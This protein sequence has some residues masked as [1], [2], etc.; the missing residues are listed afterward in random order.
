[1]AQAQPLSALALR[2][3][4]RSTRIALDPRM[5][6][7]HANARRS[8]RSGA[9]VRVWAHADHV[10]RQSE[11]ALSDEEAWIDGGAAWAVM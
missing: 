7:R 2:L 5:P 3:L 4:L 10:A 1:M 8:A 6:R 9:A 11:D